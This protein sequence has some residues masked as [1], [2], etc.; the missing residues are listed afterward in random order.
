MASTSPVRRWDTYWADLNYPVGSEQGGARRP[1]IVV[2]NDGFNR[3]FP[4]VTVV[5]L[6]K[7]A[8][9]KRRVYPFEV[10]IAAGVAG[11]AQQSIVM[12]YQVRTIDKARLLKPLGRLEDRLLRREIEDRLMEHLGVEL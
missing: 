4:V 1:V 10:L 5:P 9:K 6:T 8:G 12:P 3:A 2:S 7:A 11:N